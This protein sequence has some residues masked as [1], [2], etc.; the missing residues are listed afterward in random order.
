[1]FPTPLTVAH[2]KMGGMSV[3]V[4]AFNFSFM[5]G[6][7]GVAVGEGL[8]AASRLAVVQDAPLIVIPSSGGARMQEGIRR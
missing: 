6:S 4:A 7:M 2:G 1:M 3:V 8:L 5:G